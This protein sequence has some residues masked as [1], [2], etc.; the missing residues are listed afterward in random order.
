MGDKETLRELLK[1]GAE[2][3]SDKVYRQLYMKFILGHNVIFIQLVYSALI[4]AIMGNM[5][6]IVAILLNSGADVNFV[7]EVD[8]EYNTLPLALIEVVYF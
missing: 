5:R 1:R 2:I 7:V 4:S 3:E 6:D 8:N